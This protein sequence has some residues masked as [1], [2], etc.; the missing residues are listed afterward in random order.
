MRHLW[1]CW[2]KHWWTSGKNIE[3]VTSE[4]VSRI[5]IEHI[6][7]VISEPVRQS[8]DKH[9]YLQ[10]SIN[11][12][13]IRY[14]KY[15]ESSTITSKYFFKYSFF[16]DDLKTSNWVYNFVVQVWLLW[17]FVFLSIRLKECKSS[18][19]VE[20]QVSNYYNVSEKILLDQ[21]CFA[22]FLRFLPK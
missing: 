11:I 16:V 20:E 17:S 10:E 21:C 5:T 7:R 3:R 19:L 14:I 13:L 6:S 12:Y 22:L 15:D 18:F 2:P 1:T 4:H 9:V 8:N